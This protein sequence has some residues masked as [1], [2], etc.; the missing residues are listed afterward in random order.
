MQHCDICDLD[1]SA[2][3]MIGGRLITVSLAREYSNGG[4]L[5]GVDRAD[6]ATRVQ[7]SVPLI[8]KVSA[9]V[10]Y[11]KTDSSIEYFDEEGPSIDLTLDW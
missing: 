9:K 7:V 5:L 6:R 3:K 8:E 11:A 2:T 4:K 10:G 1:A